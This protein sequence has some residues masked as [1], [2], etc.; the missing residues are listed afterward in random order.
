MLLRSC[1]QGLICLISLTSLVSAGELTIVSPQAGV[2]VASQQGTVTGIAGQPVDIVNSDVSIEVEI[3]NWGFFS[4]TVSIAA[5]MCGDTPCQRATDE[6][7]NELLDPSGHPV[8]SNATDTQY[9]EE[10]DFL[11]RRTSAICI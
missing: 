6:A 2:C 1:K 7:G 9:K 11:R 4:S 3:A 8:Y 10:S 5:H